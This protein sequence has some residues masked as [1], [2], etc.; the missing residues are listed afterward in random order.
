[1]SFLDR[2]K[3][4]P[5]YKSPDPEQRVAGVQD[6]TDTPEDAAV[7][8]TLAREDADARVRRAALARIQ[9]MNVLADV[10]AADGGASIRADLIE[11]LANGAGSSD[12]ADAALRAL[13]ALT[14]PKQIGTV[15]KSSPV[16]AV[17][18]EAVGRLTDV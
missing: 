3:I 13:A 5:R 14:D 11:G 17:R 4:Q 2:F 9:D 18:V 8:V 10:A 16:E 1:M 12:S 6:L 15:A 7:L